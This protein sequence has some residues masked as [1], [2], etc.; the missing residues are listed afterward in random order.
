MYT[1]KLKYLQEKKIKSINLT[2][3]TPLN[4]FATFTFSG[5]FKEGSYSY[6][7][8]SG[9]DVVKEGLAY[10]GFISVSKNEYESE[11][12]IVNYD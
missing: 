7:I 12:N 3:A 4:R 1:L 8:M 6:K 11:I 9:D 2:D 10:S 5:T